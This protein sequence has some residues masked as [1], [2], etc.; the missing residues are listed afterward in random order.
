MIIREKRNLQWYGSVKF[1]FALLVPS[2]VWGTAR[3]NKSTYVIETATGKHINIEVDTASK[4]LPCCAGLNSTK[5]LS[6]FARRGAYFILY[7]YLHHWA[8]SSS[9][10]LT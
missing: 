2:R 6:V 8:N 10:H 4:V 5:P 1:Q 7:A 3:P 9:V